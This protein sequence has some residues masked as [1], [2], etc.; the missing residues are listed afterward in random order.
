MKN[1]V[2]ALAVIALLA[3]LSLGAFGA[4]MYYR[5]LSQAESGLSLHKR[6]LELY[7]QSDAFKGRLEENRLIEEGQKIEQSASATL[8]LA[9]SSRLWALTSSIASIIFILVSVAATMLHL[10][11]KEVVSSP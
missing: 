10:K 9:S 2:K 3:G 1:K 8:L 11:R 7:D 4:W 6:S 5:A